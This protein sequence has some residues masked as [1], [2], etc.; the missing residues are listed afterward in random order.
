MNAMVSGN[1]YKGKRVL[2]V[3]L[4]VLG[5]GLATTK[6]FLRRGAE[7]TVTDLRTRTALATSIRGLGKDAERIRFVLGRH[8][9]EDFRAHDLV[10]VNPAV[11]RE[12]P[13]LAVAKRAGRSIVNDA[14]IFFDEVKGPVVAVTGTRGKTT[15]ANWIA[16]CLGVRAGGNSSADRP[17]LKLL[18]TTKRGV[19]IVVELSSWQLEL[20]GRSGRAPD[21]ALITNIHRDHMNRYGSMAAYARAKANIFKHQTGSQ[22]VIMNAENPWTPFL[23]KLFVEWRTK[24]RPYFFSRAPLA[25]NRNGA[26]V[27]RGAIYVRENGRVH[28]VVPR[29]LYERCA[30]WGTHNIENLLATLLAAHFAGVPWAT[31]RTRIRTLPQV[32]F[33]QET[34][35]SRK[36]LAVVN[37]SAGTSPDAT[38]V[39]LRRFSVDRTRIVLLA[40]G[41]D[42]N[43]DFRDWAHVVARTIPPCDLLLLEGTATK[44]MISAL[45][46][47]GYFKKEEPRVFAGLPAM[48]R[49]ARKDLQRQA[50]TVLFSPGAASFEKFKNEFDR[51]EKFNLYCRQIIRKQ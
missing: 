5:G 7:V 6:W 1:E 13:F 45:R 11:P 43:L 2:I 12:S 47:I 30:L 4:G 49:A 38:I 42:K 48:L 8:D 14:S 35:L 31:L 9:V 28:V 3:G 51:G 36:G 46:R 24:S 17:L 37:D 44:K 27:D 22:R 15:T 21:V 26:F 39:A 16:H 23:M 10:V 29:E 25:R 40:G 50:T 32:P 41:T 33:R 19:P 34:V 20:V 18:D